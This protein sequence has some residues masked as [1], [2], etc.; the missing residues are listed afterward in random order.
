[1]GPTQAR[2]AHQA[3][4]S[5]RS[6][7]GQEN[8]LLLSRNWQHDEIYCGDADRTTVLTAALNLRWPP[9]HGPWLAKK[10]KFTHSVNGDFWPSRAWPMTHISM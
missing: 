10:A 9:C 8:V 7:K 5:P 1:M 2:E 3:A 6:Q 4:M